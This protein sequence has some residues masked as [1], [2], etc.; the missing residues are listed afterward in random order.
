[1]VLAAS[2][3]AFDRPNCVPV[4]VRERRTADLCGRLIPS[5][6]WGAR[7]WDRGAIDGGVEAVPRCTSTKQA[8]T[9]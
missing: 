7:G 4:V 8:R 9:S 3:A 5:A 1:M 2:A 6:V